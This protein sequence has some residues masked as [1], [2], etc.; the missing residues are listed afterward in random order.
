MFY[1]AN[2]LRNFDLGYDCGRYSS[3]TFDCAT[4]LYR[5]GDDYVYLEFD[6]DPTAMSS[7]V[8]LDT[9]TG[10]KHTLLEGEIEALVDVSPDGQYFAV[11]GGHTR[12]VD[13]VDNWCNIS[14]DYMDYVEN[15]SS[16]YI[17]K[18]A[19]YDVLYEAD[20]FVN[21]GAEVYWGDSS[22]I[23]ALE[24]IYQVF[25]ITP[26]SDPVPLR[27]NIWPWF[28][29][30]ELSDTGELES[31]Y[32]LRRI[33]PTSI[34][35]VSPSQEQFIIGDPQS[36]LYDIR[37]QDFIPIVDAEDAIV[38]QYTHRYVWDASGLQVII[39][40]QEDYNLKMT[41]RIVVDNLP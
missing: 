28:H 16:L 24:S 5:V 34:Q 26:D 32:I 23:I 31:G 12:R 33:S 9:E 35:A 41:Y 25:S 3:D 21:Y 30:L 27:S 7:V 20:G 40:S 39:S 6:E 38:D 15:E 18:N 10:E 14:T 22:I 17:V 8:L 1:D 13:A 11:I 2:G 36:S 19:G 29:V 37:S 4:S